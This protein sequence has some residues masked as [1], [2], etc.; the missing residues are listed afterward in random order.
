M[1]SLTSLL[2]TARDALA[3]Q[4]FGVSVTGQNIS[5]V[6][7]PGYTRR[8]AV[9]ETHALGNQT[10][11][12]ISIAGLKR[13][14]DVYT[15]RRHFESS[16]LASAA[17]ERDN[18]LASVESLFNDMAGGG[19]GSSLDAL[20]NSFSAL[21][22]NPSDPSARAAVLERAQAFATRANETG[23]A[24]GSTRDAMFAQARE[25]TAEVNQRA[26]AVAN[27]NRRIAEAEAG[28][29][30]AADLKDQRNQILLGLAQ[31]VD[32]R[33][34]QDGNGALVVQASGTTLVEGDTARSLSVDLAADGS[35]RLL[36][37]RGNSQPSEITQFLTGG[38]LAGIR[39]ARDVDLKAISTKLDDFVTDVATALN[40][41][42][43]AGFG[44]DGASG[45][46]LFSFTAG[47]GAARTLALDSS[48]AGQPRNIAAAGSAASLPGGS[49]NAAALFKLGSSNVASGN[50]RSPVA[51]YSDLV[52]EVGSR[53]SQAAE[54][55]AIRDSLLSQAE[56][57]RESVSGVSLDEE[58]I[59]LTKYQRAYDAASRV[60]RTVDEM[61]QEL[62]SRLG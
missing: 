25:T 48:V 23:D 7:T 40:A 60:L 2:Y 32:V 19:L 31:L 5:N 9:L 46:N 33:T 36:A 51:A 14:S 41:Q 3:A 13:A 53:K 43:A 52:G 29:H 11:G 22:T 21:S 42:H 6:N 4:S 1:A 12:S 49:D 28:G 59:A 8:E 55:V 17:S 38:K 58:M 34:F 50:T 27:L 35:L 24:L 56:A 15:E 47:T 18:Q 61:L 39:E 10:T 26:T 37:Q 57:M 44:L 45:R 16:G 20:F 54:T 30:D 62:M